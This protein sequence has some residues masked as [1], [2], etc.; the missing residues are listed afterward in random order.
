[1]AENFFDFPSEEDWLSIEQNS[2]IDNLF[3]L[4]DECKL[5]IIDENHG[6][7]DSTTL[8][9]LD[10]FIYDLYHR[11]G[12]VGLSYIFM[13]FY[14]QKGIPDEKLHAESS[15]E[16][17]YWFPNFEKKHWNIKRWFDYFSDI[18]YYQI[19]SSWDGVGH[20]INEQY[21]LG[22]DLDDVS[23]RRIIKPLKN[24]N[25]ELS[26][27]LQDL[28]D[29]DV[30]KTALRIRNDIAHKHLPNV[31]GMIVVKQKSPSIGL[32]GRS[33]ASKNYVPSNQ[34]IVNSKDFL[35]LFAKTLQAIIDATE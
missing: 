18:F 9:S 29:S 19:F 13:E 31:P 3:T 25:Q 35:D 24:A 6:A 7:L 4:L 11:I 16:D 26:Q 12:Y 15:G 21:Q 2:S 5:K 33:Y 8:L 1:M 30:Y 17:N 23:F 10:G 28:I 27:K 34:I 22:L 32:S 14:H 20:L